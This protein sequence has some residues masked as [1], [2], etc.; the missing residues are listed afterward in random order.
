MGKWWRGMDTGDRFP[1]LLG[2]LDIAMV[3][4]VLVGL[5]VPVLFN[6]YILFALLIIGFPM[7]FIISGSGSDY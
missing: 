4:Y 6:V 3:A 7:A 1:G 5:I 2:L